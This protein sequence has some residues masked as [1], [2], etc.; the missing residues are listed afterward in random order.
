M[1]KM[2]SNEHRLSI[3]ILL[4]TEKRDLCVNE[5]AA[6]VGISQ[7]LASHQLSSLGM[8]GIVE[9]HRMGQTICYQPA[10][11]EYAQRVFKVVENIIILEQ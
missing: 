1:L 11:N 9:A 4:Y 2:I 7:S 10:G 3:L 6:T 8:A 5:I